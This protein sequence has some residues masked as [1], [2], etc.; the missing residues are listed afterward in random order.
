[1]KLLYHR[2]FGQATAGIIPSLAHVPAYGIMRATYENAGSATAAPERLLPRL[3]ITLDAIAIL[4]IPRMIARWTFCTIRQ[5][6]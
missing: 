4:A 2:R 3:F 5:T 1:M 6:N